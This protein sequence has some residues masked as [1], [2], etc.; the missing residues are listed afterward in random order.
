MSAKVLSASSCAMQSDGLVDHEPHRAHGL[1][2]DAAWFVVVA[3]AERYRRRGSR[4]RI[5]CSSRKY[6]QPAQRRTFCLHRSAS[7]SALGG[8]RP[9]GHSAQRMS[10]GAGGRL[11]LSSLRR[12]PRQP[13]PAT[14]AGARP[15][16]HATELIDRNSDGWRAISLFP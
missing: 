10:P 8:F 13:D 7:R 3:V 16:A 12:A 6:E 11:L 9:T 4:T 5:P 14:M 15:V 1:C 2:T